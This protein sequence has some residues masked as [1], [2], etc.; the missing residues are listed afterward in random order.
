MKSGMIAAD[1]VFKKLFQNDHKPV[2]QG[3]DLETFD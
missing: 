3:T 2:T 1:V